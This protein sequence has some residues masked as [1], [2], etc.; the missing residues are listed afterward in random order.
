MPPSEHV[1]RFSVPPRAVHIAGSP[2]PERTFSQR[3]CDAA[4]REARQRGSDEATQLLERQM[5]D[6]R[7]DVMHLQTATFAKLAATHADLI[8][9]FRELVPGLVIEAASRVLAATPVSRDTV[10]AVVGEMLRG[11]ENSSPDLE[12]RLAQRDL[13]LIAGHEDGFREKHPALTFRADAELK[14]GDCVVQSRFGM[15]DGRTATKLQLCK[16]ALH[17]A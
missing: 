15:L 7:A 11:V 4:C 17:V 14:P 3:E 12:V 9:Q 6:L 16:E 1:I 10:L 5:L 13:E 8:A 2:P